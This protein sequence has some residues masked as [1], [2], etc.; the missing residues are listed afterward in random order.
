MA[1]G[2]VCGL[3]A[4]AVVHLRGAWNQSEDPVHADREPPTHPDPHKDYHRRGS[5]THK[6]HSHPINLTYYINTPTS[7]IKGIV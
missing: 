7:E 4:G 6:V 5:L 1:A 2:E 3:S